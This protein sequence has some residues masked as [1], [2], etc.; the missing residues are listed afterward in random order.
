MVAGHRIATANATAWRG[1]G[2][3]LEVGVRPE[4][5][6]FS[7]SGIPVDV[8]KVADAGRHRIVETRHGF[9]TIKMLVQE[10]VEIPQGKAHVA[11]DPP[12]TQVYD[13]GWVVESN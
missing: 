3:S 5:V 1:N 6:T 4:F 10:D 11:F 12:H 8:V 2:K 13:N 7:D 9:M